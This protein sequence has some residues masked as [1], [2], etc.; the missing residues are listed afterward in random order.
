M[1]VVPPSSPARFVVARLVV[2]LLWGWTPQA[3]ASD[4]RVEASTAVSTAAEAHGPQ[5]ADAVIEALHR[6]GDELFESGDYAGAQ[7]AWSDAF[8]RVPAQAENAPYRVTLLALIV[9]AALAQHAESG[10]QTPLAEVVRLL[11]DARDD[12]GMDTELTQAID[13]D[14]SR[15]RALVSSVPPPVVPLGSIVVEGRVAPR[16][17]DPT[18]IMI[19]S[20]AGATAAGIA[21]IAAGAA[22]RPRAESMVSD[23]GDSTEQGMGFVDDEVAKGRGWIGAGAAVAAAGVGVLVTGIV[24][25]VR[26]RRATRG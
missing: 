14:L 25:R 21:A 22:F 13:V 8:E 20:G 10:S 11:L 2:P 9:E 16:G 18:W 1:A 4:E 7:A 6:Q 19:G 12:P 24:L 5:A 17:P 23:S 26:S 15:V 3:S